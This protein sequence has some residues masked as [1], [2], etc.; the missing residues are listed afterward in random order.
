VL[1]DKKTPQSDA[2]AKALMANGA[3][4]TGIPGMKEPIRMWSMSGMV[5]RT[6]VPAATLWLINASNGMPDDPSPDS[7][8]VIQLPQLRTEAGRQALASLKPG[9]LANTVWTHQTAIKVTIIR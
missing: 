6:D 1:I 5:T 4:L 7:G 8:E 9:D 3:Q 2:R